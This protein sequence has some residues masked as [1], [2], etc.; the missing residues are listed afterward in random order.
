MYWR[1]VTL[2]RHTHTTEPLVHEPSA[3]EFEMAIEKLKEHKS[4]GT[5]PITAELFKAGC[6][7][8]RSEIHRLIISI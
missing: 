4:P 1:L 2:G 7:T 3:F 5:D 8:I 6:R